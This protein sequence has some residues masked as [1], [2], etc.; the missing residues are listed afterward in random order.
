M[1]E[2]EKL[3]RKISKKDRES[4]LEIVEELKSKTR[5][6]YSSIQKVSGT[7]FYRL[8][9]GRYRIIFHYASDGVIIDSIRLRN[10]RTYKAL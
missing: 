6:L 5:S 3:F 2:I 10:E 1:N 4:L 7:E 8:K 9:K